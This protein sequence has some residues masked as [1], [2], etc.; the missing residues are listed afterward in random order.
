MNQPDWLVFSYT[1]KKRNTYSFM[2]ITS[3]IPVT[4]SLIQHIINRVI[5]IF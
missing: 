1:N 2:T 3:G 4:D 5:K